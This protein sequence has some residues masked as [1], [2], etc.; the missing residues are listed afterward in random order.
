[1]TTHLRRIGLV[2]PLLAAALAAVPVPAGAQAWPIKPVRL[3]A[4][5][6]PGGSSDLVAR[7]VAHGLGEALGQQVITE[8]RAGAGGSIGTAMVA[9]AP[10]DG[11]T[12]L[13]AGIGPIA[14]NVHL[15]AD[16]GYDPVRDLAAITPVAS[17]P[18][19]LVGHPSVP[20]KTVK[21]L[22][23]LARRKPGA[24]TCGSGG[25]GT[26]AHLGCEMFKLLAKVDVL[27]V[28]YKG[29]GQAINDLIGGQIHLVFASTPVGVPNLR[30]G[31]LR[32][33]AVTSTSRTPQA[34]DLPTL[35]EAGVKGY[36]FDSWWGA[37]MP[38]RTPAA[39]IDRVAADIA[40]VVTGGEAK[41]RFGVLG[42]DPYVLS[43]AAFA[44][45]VRADVERIGQLVRATGIRAD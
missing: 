1:M 28:A 8:N 14:T 38:A 18:T 36:V 30:N 39:I 7:V 19:M 4:P 6:P 15:Y 21:E 42:L 27:H 25:V 3:V 26:P 17:A 2:L 43:P 35:D 45:L 37:F 5:F 40:K 22:L 44:A 9:K 12:L 11:Y 24:L 32:G 23:A 10:A 31:K 29:S 34:P 41:E 20:A 16:V 33:Y 13:L